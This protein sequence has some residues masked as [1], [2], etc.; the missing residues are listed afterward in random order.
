MKN[1]SMKEGK[2]RE[3]D[4]VASM[5]LIAAFVAQR[6]K[7]AM[8]YRFDFFISSVATIAFGVVNISLL[9]AICSRIPNLLGWSFDELL[10]I[11][12]LGELNVGILFMFFS[13]LFSVPAQQIVEG[14]LDQK[15]VRPLPVFLQLAAEGFSFKDTIIIAKGVAIV[16]YAS[17]RLSLD[18]SLGKVL[19]VVLLCLS[20]GAIYAS[21]F[22]IF[23]SLSFWVVDRTGLINPLFPISDFSRFPLTIYP[24]GIRIFLTYLIPFAFVAFYPATV[25]VGRA[26]FTA[27][28]S[29]APVVAVVFGFIASRIWKAGLLRYESTGT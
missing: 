6:I 9:W 18:L 13:F 2:K 8:A 20:A 15:L 26:E 3:A 21:V 28:A 7:V 22:T 29:I 10:L 17:S 25:I 23:T 5:G 19:F 24:L 4:I 27:M 11:Y 14:R 12:G 16:A 1:S